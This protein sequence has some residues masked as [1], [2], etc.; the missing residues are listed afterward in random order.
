M[1]NCCPVCRNTSF[2]SILDKKTRGKI[3][4]L[5]VKC[6]NVPCTWTGE[7]LDLDR[8]TARN[9]QYA[10]VSCRLGCGAIVTRI[11][12][13]EHESTACDR[14]TA[15]NK[16]KGLQRIM[17]M[18]VV[19]ATGRYHD[20]MSTTKPLL[21]GFQGMF[22]GHFDE[23][24][25][26]QKESL[27]LESS[28]DEK[29]G[30]LRGSIQNKFEDHEN[31][32]TKATN[33]FESSTKTVSTEVMASVEETRNGLDK[34]KMDIEKLFAATKDENQDK[35]SKSTQT[36]IIITL[37][38]QPLVNGVHNREGPLCVLTV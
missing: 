4:S 17:L 11:T 28:I 6:K 15:D 7:L 1:N 37:I 35:E 22:N 32:L 10:M 24:S 25:N 14:R 23:I 38:G 18:K 26:Q 31:N 30:K 27:E 21:P 29:I 9:C 5:K 19:E 13:A 12:L 33:T 16:L 34:A 8:H 3:L 2:T 20:D 36:I